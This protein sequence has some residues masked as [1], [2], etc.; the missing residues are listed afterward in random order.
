MMDYECLIWRSAA[1]THIRKLQVMQSE[2][3][4]IATNAPRYITNRQIQ[5]DL[6]IPFFAHHISSIDCTNW[7]LTEVT[8]GQPKI[9]NGQPASRGCP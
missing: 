4:H 1:Y 6:G 5:E 3:L 9:T 8:R 7:G 2:R